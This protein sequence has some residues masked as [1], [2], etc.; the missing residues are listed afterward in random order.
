MSEAAADSSEVVVEYTSDG[1]L[2]A[3]ELID[4]LQ[5]LSASAVVYIDGCDCTGKAGGIR[6]YGDGSVAIARDETDRGNW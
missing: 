3:G 1:P 4:K 2:T 5:A 6:I